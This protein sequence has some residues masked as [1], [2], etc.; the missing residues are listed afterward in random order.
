V[1]VWLAA[2]ISV[3]KEEAAV[4]GV[5]SMKGVKIIMAES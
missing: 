5:M 1:A 4:E 3:L 2:K